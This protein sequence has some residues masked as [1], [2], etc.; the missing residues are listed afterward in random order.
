MSINEFLLSK[1]RYEKEPVM[2]FFNVKGSI[3]RERLNGM[4]RPECLR[5]ATE[6]I[7]LSE[8]DTEWNDTDDDGT[9]IPNVY[10]TWCY[11]SMPKAN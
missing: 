4:S 2:F 5:K 11:V 7:P 1:E 8:F 6:A 9:Y 10:E 3:G